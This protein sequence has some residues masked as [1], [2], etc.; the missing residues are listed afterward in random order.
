ILKE[1]LRVQY[2]RRN[3]VIPRDLPEPGPGWA[4]TYNRV[5][6]RLA[7]TRPPFT[8]Y[9]EAM[10]AVRARIAPMLAE[11]ADEQ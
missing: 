8:T 9:A 5:V 10:G 6:P 7:G 11:L 4:D 1:A 3:M 2:E